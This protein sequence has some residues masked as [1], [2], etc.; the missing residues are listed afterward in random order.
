LAKFFSYD[1]KTAQVLS[2]IWDLLVLNFL[3]LIGSLPVVTVGASAVAAYSVMLKII[4]DRDTGIIT[5]YIRAYRANLKQGLILSVMAIA[6]IAAI[7]VDFFLFENTSGNPIIFL[8]LGFLSL[9]LFHVHFF[10]VFALAARYHNSI[11][12]HLSNSRE[13]FARFIV[14]SLICTGIAAFEAWLFFFYDWLLLFVGVFIAPI[15]II[16]TKSAFAL[17]LFHTIE[18]ESELA[19]ENRVK[20]GKEGGEDEEEDKG[21]K[22]VRKKPGTVLKKAARTEFK[23]KRI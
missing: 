16:G 22:G 18:A 5:E 11:F 15:L 9:V 1:S 3:F 8:I 7:Y 20:G 14:R 10:Y 23:L 6:F 21:E 17:R 19:K 4:E 13:I 2:R 12:N